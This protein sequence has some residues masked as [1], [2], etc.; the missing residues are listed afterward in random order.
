MPKVDTD[1]TNRSSDLVNWLRPFCMRDGDDVSSVCVSLGLFDWALSHPALSY[2]GILV[3]AGV[4]FYVPG[5]TISSRGDSVRAGSRL[6][7]SVDTGH[8]VPP[9]NTRAPNQYC[10]SR[11][12]CVVCSSVLEL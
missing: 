6:M 4:R 1:V 10:F 2:M 3:V 7:V 8:V 11:F 12:S 9:I 5:Q